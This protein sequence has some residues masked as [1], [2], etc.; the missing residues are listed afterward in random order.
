MNRSLILNLLV[1][2]TLIIMIFTLSLRTFHPVEYAI[3]ALIVLYNVLFLYKQY[4]QKFT[5][6]EEEIGFQ[7]KNSMN[8]LMML[9]ITT[10]LATRQEGAA[11]PGLIAVMAVISM[12]LMVFMIVSDLRSSKNAA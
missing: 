9:A 1:W 3:G 8:I 10:Y 7:R 4:I 11:L 6:K 5:D 2:V 12:F